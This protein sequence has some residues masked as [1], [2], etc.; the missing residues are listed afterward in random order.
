MGRLVPIY[1]KANWD[2]MKEDM[3]KAEVPIKELA[4][5]KNNKTE[6]LYTAFEEKLKQSMKENVPEKMLK[7]KVEYLWIT[8]ELRKLI[9]KRDR[10]YRKWKKNKTDKKTNELR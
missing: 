6:T 3:I 2:K 7:K 5:D 9:R 8:N 1:K 10:I 4:E